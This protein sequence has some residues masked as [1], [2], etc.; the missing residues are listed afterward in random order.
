M[1][2]THPPQVSRFSVWNTTKNVSREG[3]KGN[4]CHC[5]NGTGILRIWI[6]FSIPIHNYLLREAIIITSSDEISIAHSR[7]LN[8]NCQHIP[9]EL[10]LLILYGFN[11][12]MC[13]QFSNPKNQMIII[14][15]RCTNITYISHMRLLLNS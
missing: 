14:G 12:T 13:E 4:A 11:F 7:Y 1:Q 9:F 5:A 10:V 3:I 15:I 2:C 6:E 8:P